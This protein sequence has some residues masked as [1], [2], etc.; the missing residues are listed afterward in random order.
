MSDALEITRE[1][2]KEYGTYPTRSMGAFN[3]ETVRDLTH[4][5]VQDPYTKE[6]RPVPTRSPR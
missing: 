2:G 4:L 5:K 1:T 3:V 6:V